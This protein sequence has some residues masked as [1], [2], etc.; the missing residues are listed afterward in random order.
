MPVRGSCPSSS[1]ARA[2]Q[3]NF[4]GGAV[5]REP[6][7]EA[8][9]QLSQLAFERRPSLRPLPPGRLHLQ[10]R[11][12]T[13]TKLLARTGRG[14]AGVDGALWLAGVGLLA[15]GVQLGSHAFGAADA[16]RRQRQTVGN[17]PPPLRGSA[18]IDCK[19]N[20]EDDG[21][22]SGRARAPRSVSCRA[23]A[24]G[25]AGRSAR[26]AALRRRTTPAARSCPP[27]AAPPAP[28]PAAPSA[29]PPWRSRRACHPTARLS[30][31]SSRRP[32]GPCTRGT[33]TGA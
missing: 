27:A 32:S 29:P 4:P 30:P 26:A 20:L 8:I 33:P 9:L 6:A 15:E 14:L 23:S 13:T 11:D 3:H 28:S 24:A 17:L 1:G 16:L 7:L 10:G 2:L 19:P 22:R 18:P 21:A 5:H 12:P 31:S 25:A